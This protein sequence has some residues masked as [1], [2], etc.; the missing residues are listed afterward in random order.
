MKLRIQ[1]NAKKHTIDVPDDANLA[2]LTKVI[3]STID[4]ARFTLKV[5]FPPRS[6]SLVDPLLTL[7]EVRIRSGETLIAETLH[8]GERTQANSTT[9]IKQVVAPVV[10]PKTHDEAVAIPS[11]KKMVLQDNF[12]FGDYGKAPTDKIDNNDTLP[13]E[14][15]VPERGVMTLRV[16]PDDNSCLFRAIG[17]LCMR[18]ID[19]ME[20]LRQLIATTIQSNPDDYSDAVLGMQRDM[21]CSKM[22]RADT[23]G[24]EIEM[25]ILSDH[26]GVQIAS[27]DCKTG[28]VYRYGEQ[29]HECIYIVYS[30]I[31]YDALAVMPAPNS[32]PD[33]DQT[34]FSSKDAVVEQAAIDLVGV[35]RKRNYFTDTASFDLRCNTCNTGLKG[36]KGAQEHAAKTGHVNFGE[37]IA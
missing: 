2:H 27:I 5:G 23:W 10:P 24:G 16:Q 33:W 29:F 11:R 12:S 6:L 35:L 18:S 17:Y 20:E 37:Y 22:N 4:G 19:A 1:Y 28:H 14:I 26:F 8:E 32:P 30:G 15:N 13:P 36:E 34:Q 21:Y 3:E 31:H 9:S 7:R 25:K